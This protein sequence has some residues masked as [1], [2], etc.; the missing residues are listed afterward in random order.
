VFLEGSAVSTRL[1][2]RKPL[3]VLEIGLGL[4]LNA[5]VTA[6]AA[7]SHSCPVEYVGIEHDFPASA[8][9]RAVLQ[10]HPQPW[11]DALLGLVDEAQ[12]MSNTSNLGSE[13]VDTRLSKPL[14]AH[15]TLQILPISLDKALCTL[16]TSPAG[17]PLF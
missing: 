12:S 14:N 3:R 1:A 15:F 8:L 13:R 9:V 6:A 5:M 7:D 2:N 4:G 17:S 10:E 11:V 16:H